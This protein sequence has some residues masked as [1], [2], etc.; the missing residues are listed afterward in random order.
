MPYTHRAFTAT[1]TIAALGMLLSLICA[2][3][4]ALWLSVYESQ[5]STERLCQTYAFFVRRPAPPINTPLKHQ[6]L[7][8]YRNLLLFNTRLGCE[9]TPQRP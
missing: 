6:E 1:V 5:R 3:G 9:T 4:G 8:Q 7:V 2:V